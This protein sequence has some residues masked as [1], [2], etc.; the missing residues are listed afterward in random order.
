V[1]SKMLSEIVEDYLDESNQPDKNAKRMG[2]D[3]RVQKQKAGKPIS[4][5][6]S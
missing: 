5:I 4:K 6:A 1:K 2:K 3:M